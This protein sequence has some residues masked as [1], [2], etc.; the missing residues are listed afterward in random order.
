MEHSQVIQLAAMPGW[1]I[2]ISHT[3]GRGY[4]CWIINPALDVLNDGTLYTTSS[5]ALTAGRT[6][7]ERHF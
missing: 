3:Q 1:I 5:A 2:G 6:F 7:V 4:E